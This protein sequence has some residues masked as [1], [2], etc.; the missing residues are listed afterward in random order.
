MCRV[1]RLEI[2]SMY[3]VRRGDIF[4]HVQGKERGHF[5][6]C[7]VRRCDI[8]I[9]YRVRRGNVFIMYM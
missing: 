9:M 8:F 3:R 4:Y 7:R 2:F 5:I 1:R 6:M